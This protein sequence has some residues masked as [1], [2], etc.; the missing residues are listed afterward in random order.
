MVFAER[1][2]S[3]ALGGWRGIAIWPVET[4]SALLRVECPAKWGAYCLVTIFKL[5][6]SM[7]K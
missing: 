7:C 1:G 6:Y 2:I 5:C 4:V 3:C